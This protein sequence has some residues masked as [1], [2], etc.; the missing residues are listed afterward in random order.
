MSRPQEQKALKRLDVTKL[1]LSTVQE[2]HDHPWTSA[3]SGWEQRLRIYG[4]DNLFFYLTSTKFN[5]QKHQDWFDGNDTGIKTLM[6]EKR[7]FHR[8][9]ENDPGSDAKK[10]AYINKRRDIKKKLRILQNAWLS[11]KADEIQSFVD[12]HDM[13]RFYDSLKCLYGPRTPGSTPILS[14]DGSRLITDKKRIL[15]RWA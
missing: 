12:R 8:E 11:Q 2:I 9:H 3:V 15:E 10:N 14:A 7:Q 13:K 1:K 4:K 5:L 6:E